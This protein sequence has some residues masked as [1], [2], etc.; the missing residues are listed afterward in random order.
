MSG[1]RVKFDETSCKMYSRLSFCS[2]AQ[3][4]LGCQWPPQSDVF[5]ILTNQTFPTRNGHIRSLFVLIQRD[6][7]YFS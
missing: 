5:W 1:N 6:L 4:L 2:F 7:Y 3:V